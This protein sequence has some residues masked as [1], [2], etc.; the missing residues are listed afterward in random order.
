GRNE[1]DVVSVLERLKWQGMLEAAV[2]G[3]LVRSEKR[4]LSSS[5]PDKPSSLPELN[6]D[7]LWMEI[8]ARLRCRSVDEE[9]QRVAEIRAA[10]EFILEELLRFKVRYP[11]NDVMDMNT[12]Q[13]IGS[14]DGAGGESNRETAGR[15]GGDGGAKGDDGDGIAEKGGRTMSGSVSGPDSGQ[16]VVRRSSATSENGTEARVTQ[17]SVPPPYV[18]VAHMLSRIDY[19]ESMYTSRKA[20]MNDIPLYASPDF[21]WRLDALYS[22]LTVAN[23]LRCEWADDDDSNG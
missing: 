5:S 17:P 12:Y 20:L 14:G 7:D 8:R 1:F 19:V 13:T 9:A 15:N 23:S 2:T 18:Q 10:S 22:W 6:I 3:D 21:Q 11:V 16:R 4:R